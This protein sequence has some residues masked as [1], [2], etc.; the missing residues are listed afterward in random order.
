MHPFLLRF[1]LI[2]SCFQLFAA[3][4]QVRW[5]WTGSLTSHG[6]VVKA[7]IPDQVQTVEL[8]LE[9]GDQ[10][11][12][13]TGSRTNDSLPT[14]A[15]FQLQD[16]K[17][18]TAYTYHL[19][20]DGQKQ[21]EP[22]GRF[23][24]AK[25]GA[26]SFK[27]AMG[28][29][30]ETGAGGD[31]FSRIIAEKPLF[32]LHLGDFHYQNIAVNE[33]AVFATAM[34][35]VLQTPAQAALYAQVPIAYM[36]D[37]HDYG[38]NNSDRSA[39]GREASLKNYRRYVP[40]YSLPFE[41]KDGPICQ[42][43]Q[44]GRVRFILADGRSQKSP[45][46]E[47]DTPQKSVYGDLQKEWLKRELLAASR[48]AELVVWVN[49]FP[50]ITDLAPGKDYWGSYSHERAELAAFI[51]DNKIDNLIMVSGDAH[52]L[53]FDDGT[54]NRFAPSGQKGF[55]V[56]H[57]AALSK[58]GSE[59]GGP[60]TDGPFPGGDQFGTM[61]ILDDGGDTVKVIL[62]GHRADGPV[63]KKELVFQPK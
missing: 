3:D 21:A 36:W 2:V 12:I 29:C 56:M 4:D 47:A 10:T 27:V 52:M 60:Y 39:P 53:A 62:T 51:E 35:I 26:F 54:N 23:K 48:Q 18:D 58:H 45:R 14:L 41:Q 49:T 40:H 11:Q 7:G 59:K 55:P 38:P 34:E 17:P 19:R 31:V 32:F 57:C 43:F 28:S 63:F 6:A 16:L 1:L 5:L 24:T 13:L 8:I 46:A 30:A 33:Q 9:G 20:L 15:R 37:D 42:S 44:I 50:W 61:E 22:V 25:A